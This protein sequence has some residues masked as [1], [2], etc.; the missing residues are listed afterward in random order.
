MWRK[1]LVDQ[2]AVCAVDLHATEAGFLADGRAAP[3]ALDDVVDLGRCGFARGLEEGRHVL[4]EGNGRGREVERVQ[5]LGRLLAR[6]V[7]LRPDGGALRGCRTRPLPQDGQVGLVLD[8]DVAGLSQSATVDHHVASQD[9]AQARG[10]PA[11]VQPDQIGRGSVV[12]GAQRLAHRRL[13]DPI[14]QHAAIGQVQR[15]VQQIWLHGWLR[16]QC[17]CRARRPSTAAEIPSGPGTT[18]LRG[19][20]HGWS[21]PCCPGP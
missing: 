6:M 17:G 15:P 3:E 5:P 1:E 12:V 13:G 20:P 8:G 16:T 19:S 21:G 9:Q 11:L 7:E 10:A 18:S 4:A 14:S 2:I